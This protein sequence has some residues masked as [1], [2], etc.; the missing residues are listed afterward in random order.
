MKSNVSEEFYQ[1]GSRHFTESQ[2]RLQISI[3]I[4]KLTMTRTHKIQLKACEGMYKDGS[5]IDDDEYKDAD[6]LIHEA[7]CS[8]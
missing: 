2:L 7:I 3:P 5:G 6:F 8:N 1:T 4:N